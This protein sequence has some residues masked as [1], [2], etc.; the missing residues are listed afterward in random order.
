MGE[1][2]KGGLLSRRDFLKLAGLGL[3]ALAL[4]DL[5]A[6]CGPAENPLSVDDYLKWQDSLPESQRAEN[7]IPLWLKR[8]IGRAHFNPLADYTGMQTSADGTA[9]VYMETPTDL[10]L[11]TAEHVGRFLWKDINV[12]FP[13]GSTNGSVHLS[14]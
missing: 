14:F 13:Y 10:V 5:L 2:G 11:T 9:Q 12:Q 8:G 3:G 7:L 4:S 1:A 6:A